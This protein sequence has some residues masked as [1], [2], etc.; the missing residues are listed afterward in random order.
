MLHGYLNANVAADLNANIKIA[1]GLKVLFPSSFISS[2]DFYM[3]LFSL[4]NI[5]LAVQKQLL[6]AFLVVVVL[7]FCF[8]IS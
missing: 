6:L 2:D 4:E 5:V 7:Y 8:N 1:L 3:V